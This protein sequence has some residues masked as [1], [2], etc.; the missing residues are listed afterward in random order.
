AHYGEGKGWL[1][2]QVRFTSQPVNKC[3]EKDAT[4]LTSYTSSYRN[5]V[6][7]Y[8]AE[9]W[10][11]GRRLLLIFTIASFLGY[12]LNNLIPTAW[13]SSLFGSGKGWSVPLAATLAIPFYLNTSSSLPIVRAFIDHGA[14]PGA[15]MAFLLVGAGTS[16]SAILGMLTIT[17]WRVIALVTVTLWIMAI[18]FGFTYNALVVAKVF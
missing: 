7:E 16:V 10:L 17:R 1:T 8:I 9:V 5:K 4:V 15:A 13:I 18:I 12:L 3:C 11:V 6:A 2:G 14:A